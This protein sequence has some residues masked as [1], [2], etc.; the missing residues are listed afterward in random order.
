M[1]AISKG[2]K[3]IRRQAVF[4]SLRVHLW[5]LVFLALLPVLGMMLYTA[6]EQ[7]RLAAVDVLQ[8]AWQVAR[9]ASVE[10][11]RLIVA[12]RQLLAAL[13]QVP[14]A[15]GGDPTACSALFA[16]VLSQAT[17]YAN[18]GTADSDGNIHCSGLPISGSVSAAHRTWFQRALHT[19]TFAVG[20]LQVGSITHRATLNFGY[21]ILDET[22]QVQTV[23]FAALELAWIN[24]LAAEVQLPPGAVLNV[25]DR[26]G[27]ILAQYPEPERWVGHSVA[28]TPMFRVILA[29]GEGTAEVHGLDRIPRLIGFTRLWG[30]PQSADAYVW[31]GIPSA[32]AFAEA[33]RIQARNLAG[34][35]GVAVLAFAAAWFGGDVFIVRR[36]QAL[37]RATKR[38]SAGDLGARTGLPYGP[39]ELGQLGRAF[40]DMAE[41]L[42]R[43]RERRLQ[44]E[45]LRRKNAELEEQ[46]R[47][48]WEVNRLK[49]EFV[50]LVSHEL[51]TPLSSIVG[52][53]ELLS[54]G[55]VGAIAPE[56]REYL[57]IVKHNIDRLIELIDDLLDI[58]RIE[59]GKVTLRRTTLDLLP[60]IQA[61]ASLLRPQLEAK[62]QRLSLD[63]PPTLP[64]V[65]GDPER[66]T[67][68]LTNLISNAY[69]YT[70]AEGS[71]SITAR[72]E[73]GRVRID[74]R[75]TGI[76]LSLDDQARLF[77][78][79]FRAQHRAT[80][81]V[82]GTGL[83]LAITRL[84]V[85][86]HGGEI[87]VTSALGQGSI[88]SFTLPATRDIQA[89]SRLA[90]QR[91][92]RA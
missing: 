77:I 7:R 45:Q 17:L 50:S 57:A 1:S 14:E 53:V 52:Y 69:K 30:L 11:E 32:I 46:N 87:T 20:A 60:L 18:L 43:L 26:H 39:G 15:R 35:G 40:D 51:R 75:D 64:P 2:R 88:F 81:A 66:L 68:I 65:L 83:G 4:S 48:V 49:T 24:Q 25:I 31:V 76:G 9:L 38:L 70:P 28:G 29:H 82:G 41:S 59:A 42:Q 44:E 78:P 8:E 91:S 12:S 47:R 19:R 72:Q 10:Q 27:T 71:I 58:S 33:N 85:E 16:D 89:T 6:S 84:L 63:L 79:F 23:V 67:Q 54:E 73:D 37:V 5:L 61:V 21:P 13:A 22:G 90:A 92:P 36:V 86:L 80:Q 55:R 56:Q 3:P 34:L 74:V 62:G